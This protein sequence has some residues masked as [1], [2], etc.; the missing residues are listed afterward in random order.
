M[1]TT[2]FLF[3]TNYHEF[4]HD[5]F[6]ELYT[7]WHNAGAERR[8]FCFTQRDYALRKRLTAF[9]QA[10]LPDNKVSHI[11]DWV[12]RQHE[13]SNAW[14][15]CED[16]LFAS[17]ALCER[18]ATCLFAW[19]TATNNERVFHLLRALGQFGSLGVFF[20]FTPNRPNEPNPAGE[21]I[22]DNSWA[23]SDNS[24]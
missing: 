20:S 14:K 8:A 13:S 10:C 3:N 15:H 21:S 11:V 19:N 1:G 17:F 18:Q 16:E 6:W 24:C 2:V 12:V 5:F 22:Y 7:C 4:D 23:I 9:P